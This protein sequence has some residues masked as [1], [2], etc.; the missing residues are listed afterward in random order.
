M[1]LAFDLV[2]P[3]ASCEALRPW[4]LLQSAHAY[5]TRCYHL[6]WKAVNG[7]HRLISLLL[8]AVRKLTANLKTLDEVKLQ[9][10]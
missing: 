4:N 10:Y 2:G 9:R 3:L 1:L 7:F 6:A 8:L 5:L